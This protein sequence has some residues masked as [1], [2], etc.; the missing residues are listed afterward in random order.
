[1]KAIIVLMAARIADSA[2]MPQARCT[3]ACSHLLYAI[4]FP[5]VAKILRIMHVRTPKRSHHVPVTSALKLAL[6][7]RIV[8][9]DVDY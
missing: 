4:M 5:S 7:S 6:K 3:V 1:M 8:N 9:V 2:N